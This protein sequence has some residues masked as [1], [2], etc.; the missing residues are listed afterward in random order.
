MQF[1][2]IFPQKKALKVLTLSGWNPPPGPR[3]LRGDLLYL[4]VTTLEEKTYH[5][6]A[7]SKGFYVNCSTEEVFDPRKQTQLGK[8]SQTYHSLVD[9]LNNLSSGFK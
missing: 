7:S 5:I 4:Y 3:K 2:S 1:V 6:T 9:L 8:A